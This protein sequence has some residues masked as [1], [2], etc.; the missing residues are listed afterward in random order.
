MKISNYYSNYNF[1]DVNAKLNFQISQKDRMYLSFYQGRDNSA[2]SND[3]VIRY[4]INYKVH[5]G[6]QA[7]ALR[8][9]HLFSPKIFSNTSVIYNNYFHDVTARQQPYYAEL[10]SGIRD[11]VFKTDFHFY[12]SLNHQISAGINYLYQTLF[13][14]TVM[15]EIHASDSSMSIIPSDIPKKYA[16]RLAAYFGDEIRLSP[17][18]SLYLGARVPFFIN[19]KAH[20]LQF[21]PRVSLMR[22]LNS[23]TSIKVSYTQMHQF[24]N[25]AQSYNASFPAEVWIGSSKIV[26]PQN[27]Q[28]ASI[29]LF[30]NCK[31][32]MFRTSLELYYKHMGNQLLFR[33]GLNPNINSDLDHSLVFGQGQSYGA[34]L[35]LSKNT[36]KLTGW[37]AYTLSYSYQQF[38]SLNLGRQFPFAN[39]RRH[40]LY[41]S[42]SYAISKH[43]QVSSNFLYTSGSAFSLFA[44][45]T[46]NPYNPMYYNNVTGGSTG[47][48][49][50][51]N[52]IQNN[53]RLAPY[54]RLDLSI[55]YRNETNFLNRNIETEWVFSVY[56]AY[57]RPNTFFAY[58]SLDP[59]TRKPIPVQV[60]FVPIIPS[61]SFYLKF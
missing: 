4:S 28:E 45:A 38:D 55:T 6:N 23:T 39:D 36:G 2:Y 46:S 33:E 1:F 53:Y 22:L 57:A 43:W 14:A 15:D 41:L 17:E 49:G 52:K 34:E 11:I 29:G 42:L 13:P 32:N 19:K 40:S 30:K 18:F 61:I 50:T 25:L 3:S 37:L 20:Y 58:C 21:E 60:S 12:P 44:D 31:E 59:A 7:M 8:W 47:P 16:S 9:N 48:G 51:D 35:Y 56:N 5:Y 54:N 10:Y 26:K 27:C 24:L